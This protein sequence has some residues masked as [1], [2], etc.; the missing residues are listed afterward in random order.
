MVIVHFIWWLPA[1]QYVSVVAF[2]QVSGILI[3]RFKKDAS[4]HITVSELA[5]AWKRLDLW[6]LIGDNRFVT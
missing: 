2:C 6:Q 4:T 1:F 5:S 3:D